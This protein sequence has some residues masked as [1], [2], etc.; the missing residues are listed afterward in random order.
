[1]ELTKSFVY[2]SI[3]EKIK[4]KI[5]HNAYYFIFAFNFGQG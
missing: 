2:E 5:T 4:V 3:T 1:M